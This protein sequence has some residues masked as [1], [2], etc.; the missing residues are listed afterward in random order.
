MNS[1]GLIEMT[2]I[3]S[4]M[5]AA[6]IMLKTSEVELLISRTICSGKYMVLIGGDVAAVQ[7]AVDAAAE[8][9]EYAVIDT[10]VIPNV[11]PDIF[12]ALSGHS[13][14]EQ[15]EA[16]GILESFSVASL[17]EGADAAV[18]AATVKIIEI[19][20]A[21]ALGGKAFCTITGEVAAVRSAVDSGAQVIADK[22]L[23][24]NKVVIA[25]PRPELLS[26]MI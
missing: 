9:I 16:L 10:F 3:A 12:P 6:D 23:L 17:I 5:E 19:R 25:Q 15:L 21:M 7:T 13:G 20:L 1:I 22:G 4:G 11:H 24:V 18:K 8:T 14:I 2:S 26:E